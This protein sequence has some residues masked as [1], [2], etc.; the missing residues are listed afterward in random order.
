MAGTPLHFGDSE[1]LLYGVFHEAETRVARAPAVLFFNP[2]GEEAI[3]AYRIFK[4]L[5]DRLARNGIAALRFDY[6]GSGDSG[7]DDLDVTI[8]GMIDDAVHAQDE[9]EA[10]SGAR[11]FVWVGL[12]LGGAIAVHTAQKLRPRLSQL[13]LW[14]PVLNGA[15]YLNDIH[16]AHGAF[17]SSVMDEPLEAVRRKLPARGCDMREA[18][19]F[20]I[21]DQFASELSAL[22]VS[23]TIARLGECH[24]MQ[25][26]QALI[27]DGFLT[28]QGGAG[29]HI[30]QFKEEAGSWNSNEALNS[31][32]V[33]SASLDYILRAVKAYS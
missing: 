2:F 29:T 31:F 15:T 11:S 25:S 17:L 19:G 21:S 22:E 13:F 8:T 18:L 30:H 16:K 4:V 3:R 9:L 10:L 33:P 1:R 28:A 23:D 12:G 5:S 26:P 20:A 27:D 7:G 6:Y 24:F 14:D 32:Y